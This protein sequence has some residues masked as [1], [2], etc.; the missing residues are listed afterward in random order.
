MCFKSYLI[1]SKKPCFSGSV[2]STATPTTAGS[3][4]GTTGTTNNATTDRCSSAEDLHDVNSQK[5]PLHP[6]LI[7]IVASLEMKPL[8]DEFNELGTEMIVT[9]AG[10]RMFPTFQVR[11]YGMD[12]M[13]DYN[14][15]MDFVPVDDKRY[16]YAFHT[17][18][19]VVAGKADPTSPPRYV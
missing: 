16:R 6:K 8:W 4:V 14:L 15:I 7:G 12:Q 19:W 2:S 5:K 9:K 17:S 11:L 13:E 1:I 10:R 3:N 18:N